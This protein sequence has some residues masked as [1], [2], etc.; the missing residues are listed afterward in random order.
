LTLLGAVGI[1]DE[2]QDGVP[3]CIDL[4]S[5]AGVNMW[6]IT[7]DKPETAVAIGRMCG[8]VGPQHELE[9]LVKARGESLRFRLAEILHFFERKKV[10]CPDD[11]ETSS[12][13]STVSSWNRFGFFSWNKFRDHYKSG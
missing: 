4:I 6:M 5:K 1:E 7:G 10:M 3:Q 8:L 13:Y 11:D 2:L 9:M 12:V